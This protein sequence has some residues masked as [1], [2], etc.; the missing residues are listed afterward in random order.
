FLGP[1]C[2]HC[3]VV[4]GSRLP[5]ET[6]DD[7]V[8]PSDQH[9]IGM[10]TCFIPGRLS[11]H[12]LL[13]ADYAR[14]LNSLP[15]AFRKALLEGCWNVYEGQYFDHWSPDSMRIR[16]ALIGEQAW[17]PHWVG[18]DYGFNGSQ[19]AAYLFCKSPA[20]PDHPHGQTFVLEEYAATH[21]TAADYARELQRRFAGG[22]RR[23]LGWYLSPD[24]WNQRGDGHTLADQMTAATGIG[25]ERASNDRVGGAMLIYSQLDR[26]ELRIADSCSQL[27]EA[28]PSRMHDPDRPDD[29]CK[30]RGDPLD[31]CIDALRYGLYSFV[32]PAKLPPEAALQA[33]IT[34]RDPT[35]AMIQRQVA[36][37]RWRKIT[38]PL[39]YLPRRH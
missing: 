32:A 16:R 5:Y 21:L 34:S 36:E 1:A 15:G 18:I 10:S 11:D 24:A 29:I 14:A 35:V 4:P 30:V 13:G 38:E 2:P 33:R 12:D 28:L 19:A 26:G 37:E 8:W 25:F 20:A 17:W 9:P 22:E 31:D 39:R 27:C 3:G 6:Y 23:I 7:A